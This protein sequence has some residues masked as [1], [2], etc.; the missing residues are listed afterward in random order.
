[1]RFK[2]SKSQWIEAGRKAG[3]MKTASVNVMVSGFPYPEEKET[4]LDLCFFIMR[5]L[6]YKTR[7]FDSLT[8]EEKNTFYQTRAPELL[9]PDTSSSHFDAPVGVINAYTSGIPEDKIDMLNG[10]IQHIL[11]QEGI[12]FETTGKVEPSRLLASG[13]IRYNIKRN[14]NAEMVRDVP[15]SLNLAN[16]NARRIFEGILG[17]QIGQPI[18]VND[19]LRRIAQVP[20]SRKEEFSHEGLE[21]GGDGMARMI[22]PPK[23]IEYYDRRLDTIREIAE[24]AG[25]HGYSTIYVA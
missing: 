23:E 5:Q 22:E 1:M 21:E 10:Q 16:G 12:D 3:W 14:P 18:D 6:E 13:V 20:T 8:P 19:L 4:L 2:I 9:T 7:F 25:R 24:W 15:P 11:E 17:F